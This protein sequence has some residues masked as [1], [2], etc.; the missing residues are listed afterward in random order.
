VARGSANILAERHA[1]WFIAVHG[2]AYIEIPALPASQNYTVKWVTQ[3]EIYAGATPQDRAVTAQHAARLS[4]LAAQSITNSRRNTARVERMGD[5]AMF[6]RSC[7]CPISDVCEAMTPWLDYE[8]QLESFGNASNPT[9]HLMR[10]SSRQSGDFS[11]LS[12]RDGMFWKM[13]SMWSVK[14]TSLKKL[15]L[16]VIDFSKP[17]T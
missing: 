11:R 1:V 5:A 7:N 17:L 3:G 9:P 10:N 13:D 14:L 4:R 12:I 16:T 6:R 8:I 15:W 2:P